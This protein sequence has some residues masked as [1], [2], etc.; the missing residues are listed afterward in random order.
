[1]SAT[2]VVGVEGS[3]L[4]RYVAALAAGAGV[5]LAVVA[6]ASAAVAAV[7]AAAAFTG[8][9]FALRP[10]PSELTALMPRR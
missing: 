5:A 3:Y 4:A 8:V 2:A 7:A 1:M 6:V 9:A 10:V